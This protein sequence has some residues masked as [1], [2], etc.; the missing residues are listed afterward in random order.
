MHELLM[1]TI[2][3]NNNKKKTRCFMGTMPTKVKLLRFPLISMEDRHV[4]DSANENH[5]TLQCTCT[6]EP[7]KANIQD[8]GG[9]GRSVET[10]KHPYTMSAKCSLWIG[11]ALWRPLRVA[12]PGRRNGAVQAKFYPLNGLSEGM[13]NNFLST[14]PSLS[15]DAFCRTSPL[16]HPV[17]STLTIHGS[18]RTQDNIFP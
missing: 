2:P 18:T 13:V 10:K 16:G 14:S 7:H 17:M 11:Y 6:K 8:G 1:D 3:K 4:R 5:G 9:G 15:Q 12:P